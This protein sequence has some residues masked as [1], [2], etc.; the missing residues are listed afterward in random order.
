MRAK[1]LLA[2]MCLKTGLKHAGMR[3]EE[4]EGEEERERENERDGERWRE[5]SRKSV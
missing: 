3:K 2:A 4:R 5:R 1:S